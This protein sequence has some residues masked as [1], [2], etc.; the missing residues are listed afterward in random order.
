MDKKQ[1]HQL[2]Q[3]KNFMRNFLRINNSREFL[4]FLFFLSIAFLFWYLMT[5][6]HEYEMKYKVRLELEHL[7]ENLIVI[8]PLEKEMTVVLKDKGDKLVEY[9][10][11]GKM[12]TLTIDHRHHVNTKGHTA[13]YGA[14]LN[15]FL[16]AG[17]AS[18]T[19]IVSVSLDTLQYYIADARGVK[20]PVRWQGVVEAD[21]QHAIENVRVVPDSVVVYAAPQVRDTL[22][23]VYASPVHLVGL[24]D[25]VDQVIDLMAGKRGIRYE[26]SAVVLSAAVSPYVTK[27]VQVPVEG[28]MFPYGQQLKTFPSKVNVSFR[29][30][31]SD[32]RD[33]TDEDFKIRVR[34]SQLSDN[35]SGKVLLSVD[36]MPENVSDVVIEPNEVDYLI[37]VDASL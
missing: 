26:P 16:S 2:E 5:M 24:A 18:S 34:H 9:K 22:T 7:P 31:L 8:E 12:K 14:E 15:K 4:V 1:S 29:V 21:K 36:E 10:A 19:E 28:Y 27:I 30:S 37:E 3:T 25:S 32:F 6:N 20:L 13:I 23:A 11:R 35:A 33:V 17:L